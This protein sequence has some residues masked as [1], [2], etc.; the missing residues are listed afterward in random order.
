MLGERFSTKVPPAFRLGFVSVHV[1]SLDAARPFY[2]RTLGLKLILDRS[3]DDEL[4]YDLGGM[5]L[6]VHVDRDGTCGRP[7]GGETG[8]YLQVP[9]LDAVARELGDAVAWREGRTLGVRDPDG[10]EYVFWQNTKAWPPAA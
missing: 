5:P 8:F 7:P 1:R 2:E 10:N 3:G 6:S 4:F 9:D